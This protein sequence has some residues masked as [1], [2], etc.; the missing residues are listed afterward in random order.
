MVVLKELNLGNFQ[1]GS[2]W[3]SLNKEFWMISIFEG[4]GGL[5]RTDVLSFPLFEAV[6]VRRVILRRQS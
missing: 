1:F 2:V 3:W 6:A 5:E 4:F